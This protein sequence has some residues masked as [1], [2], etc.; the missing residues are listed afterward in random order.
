VSNKRR[1]PTCLRAFGL[2]SFYIENP[3]SLISSVESILA[4]SVAQI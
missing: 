2:V 1:S 3:Y 4:S